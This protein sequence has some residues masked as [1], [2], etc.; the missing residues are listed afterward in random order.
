MKKKYVK[1]ML[2][3]DEDGSKKSTAI[4]YNDQTFQIDR[5]IDVK[6]CVSM[7]VG[8]I[9]ERYTIR[10]GNNTTYVFFENNKWFV[11]EK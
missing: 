11:E 1:V 9:G 6:K 4:V 5:V 8:G 2:E 10:I 3:V 7:K